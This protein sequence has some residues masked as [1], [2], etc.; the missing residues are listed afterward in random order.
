VA[1]RGTV[2]IRKDQY[3][4]VKIYLSM[5]YPKGLLSCLLE[6][7]SVLHYEELEIPE[8][9]FINGNWTVMA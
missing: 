3:K 6:I 9:M 2:R 5:T 4:H 7:C 1:R 8:E